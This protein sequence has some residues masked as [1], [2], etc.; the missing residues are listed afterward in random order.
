L[1]VSTCTFVVFVVQLL[2]LCFVFVLFIYFFQLT[3]F[4][5]ATYLLD[6]VEAVGFGN[7][8]KKKKIVRKIYDLCL[9]GKYKLK[10]LIL[11]IKGLN[12]TM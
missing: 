3:L 7:E 12:L 11:I 5:V 6:N 8:L 4:M 2:T 9:C 10:F 1:A